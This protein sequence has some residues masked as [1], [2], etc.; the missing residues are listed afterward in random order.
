MSER[1]ASASQQWARLAAVEATVREICLS[2][3]D[4]QR[5]DLRARVLQENDEKKR[6]EEQA[7]A[8]RRAVNALIPGR[9]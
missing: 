6:P 2:Y 3:T 9:R 4:R 1:R 8:F 7:A 5:D